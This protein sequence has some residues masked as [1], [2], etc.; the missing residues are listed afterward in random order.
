MDIRSV[1]GITVFE[2]VYYSDE[3]CRNILVLCI[4][5]VILNTQTN[6]FFILVKSTGIRLYL[7]FSD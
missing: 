2:K 3:Y 6:Q 7:P 4:V 1:A 5:L